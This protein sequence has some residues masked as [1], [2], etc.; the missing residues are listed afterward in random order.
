MQ[1]AYRFIPDSQLT[2]ILGDRGITRITEEVPSEDKADLQL[3]E[4]DIRDLCV[5][6][7][8]YFYIKHAQRWGT[9]SQGALRVYNLTPE[10]AKK[11]TM[12]LPFKN[13]AEGETLLWVGMKPVSMK[14][15][16]LTFTF[17]DKNGKNLG[18]EPSHTLL[19]AYAYIVDKGYQQLTEALEDEEAVASAFAPPA[20]D[21][22]ESS[23]TFK[24]YAN[25]QERF[26]LNAQAI[27][28]LVLKEYSLPEL[29]W[30]LKLSYLLPR[31]EALLLQF[32]TDLIALN[33][34]INTEGFAKLVIQ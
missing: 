10:E 20:S 28:K 4:E 11:R 32:Q 23:E 19:D 29:V 6:L 3:L 9:D 17:A 31:R 22:V 1:D 7:L 2:K 5:E 27:L 16:T 24:M 12:L 25:L 30:Q 13:S 8:Q 21:L 15:R 14:L 34:R 18:D 33:M 26:D